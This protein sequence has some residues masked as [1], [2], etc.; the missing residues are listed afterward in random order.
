MR[1]YPSHRAG[2]GPER[3]R[4]YTGLQGRSLVDPGR[5]TTT[6]AWTL[7]F[8]ISSAPE[9]GTSKLRSD[10]IHNICGADSQCQLGPTVRTG[11]VSLRPDSSP[12]QPSPQRQVWP[13]LLYQPGTG[14]SSAQL[15]PQA[16][17]FPSQCSLS[18][19]EDGR[20]LSPDLRPC[21]F[22]MQWKNSAISFQ[23]PKP[24][25]VTLG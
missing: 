6:E 24:E 19:G 7:P 10:L 4:A 13:V 11:D 12:R 8:G 5:A 25:R 22:S 9:T 15:Q 3:R 20:P 18:A 14:M 21:L 23:G 1:S 2:Q 16:W 17:R